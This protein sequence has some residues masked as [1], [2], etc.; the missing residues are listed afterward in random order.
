MKR[1]YQRYLLI[2]VIVLAGLGGAALL[3]KLRPEP[4]R[5][6]VVQS[7]PLVEVMP[8]SSRS[9]TFT[10]KS[11]GTVRPRTETILSAEVAGAIVSISP[12]FIAGG[13]FEAG[14]ELMRIDPTNYEVALEQA[15]ALVK[16]RQIEYDG[17]SRLRE[18]G[19]RAEAELASAAAALAAARAEL[20]RATRNLERTRISLPYAGIVRAKEADLGQYVNVGSRLG[21][22]FATDVAEVRL[23]LTDED[24]AFLDLPGTADR[25]ADS[26]A[27]TAAGPAVALRGRQRGELASWRARIVRTE[28]VIDEATRVSYAIAAVDDPYALDAMDASRLP[29]RV[30]TFVAAEIE[31]T[32][33]AD[34]VAIPRAAVRGNGQVVVVTE[35]DRI[36]IRDVTILR[37]DAETVYVSDGLNDG[38]L[39]SLTVI[40]NPVN[41]L[42]V[43][44]ERRGDEAELAGA[45][46]AG[47]RP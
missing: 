34:V 25:V 31:G 47:G 2:F 42:R 36:K 41:G 33:V 10:V 14:E 4:P 35:E 43:R 45:T 24:L 26:A 22:T 21:V 28:G 18:Q 9:V 20:G 6:D 46:A 12:S 13:V 15:D 1:Q 27:G 7:A 11:Q 29:L 30:G 38:D 8:V 40:E 3:S 5:K 39:I 23:P 32:T 44:P 17:A 16:Q 37:A 19:Y